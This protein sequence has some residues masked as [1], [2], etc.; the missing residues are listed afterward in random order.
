MQLTVSSQL[1]IRADS[2]RQRPILRARCRNGRR[3]DWSDVSIFPPGQM[4]S[5]LVETIVYAESKVDAQVVLRQVAAPAEHFSE[6]HEIS[7]GSPYARV[8]RQA[9]ALGRLQAES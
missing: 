4:I 9:I 5:A 3:L 8:Q 1:R 2:M 7:G 6:L